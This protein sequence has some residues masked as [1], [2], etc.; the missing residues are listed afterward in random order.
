MKY[1]VIFAMLV[2]GSSAQ[3]AVVN[4]TEVVLLFKQNIDLLE[5]TF[6]SVV[7]E[8]RTQNDEHADTIREVINAFQGIVREFPTSNLTDVQKSWLTRM[9]KFIERY[10]LYGAEYMDN[11]L[12][13]ND[14]KPSP[15]VQQS[16]L[17]YGVT[18]RQVNDQVRATL[19]GF[20]EAVYAFDI[21]FIASIREGYAP[22]SAS[23][24]ELVTFAQS[25]FDGLDGCMDSP[26]IRKCV[27][28]VMEANDAF[29][30]IELIG[31]IT[32][33]TKLANVKLVNAYNDIRDELPILRV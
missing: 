22:I 12:R 23:V 4:S 15:A 2:V 11:Y 25:V 9:Q 28:T 24:E 27:Q 1:L 18:V 8:F 21:R 17:T 5:T 30:I 19:R 29:K 6:N 7:A 16:L 20:V 33:S 32:L 14:F 10:G 3:T 13:L 31:K 26:E